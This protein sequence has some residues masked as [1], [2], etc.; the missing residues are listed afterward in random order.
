VTRFLFTTLPGTAH[1]HALGPVARAARTA[2]HDVAFATSASFRPAVEACGF[3][4]FGCGVDWLESELTETFPELARVD[5]STPQSAAH[6]M[7]LFAGRLAEAMA[8]DLWDVAQSWEPDL[9]VRDLLELGGCLVAEALDLTQAACGPTYYSDRLTL[10]AAV[11]PALTRLRRALNLPPDPGLELLYGHLELAFGPPSFLGDGAGAPATTHFLRP[12]PFDRF[13][14]AALPGTLERLSGRPT[15][16]A[17][18]GTV[19]NRTPGVFEAIVEALADAPYDV[20]LTIG[21]N[22][23][24]SEL[25]DVPANVRVV[26]YAPY[27]LLLPRCAAVITHGGTLTVTACLLASLP[28]LVLPVAGDQFVGARRCVAAGV[29]LALGR[30][31]RSPQ[32]IRHAVERLLAEPSFRRRAVELR[33]EMLNLPGPERAVELLEALVAERWKAAVQA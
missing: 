17:T 5:P 8:A 10:K 22:R 11:R 31:S 33:Q 19:S 32:L 7:E 12:E 14:A 15:I 13:E 16:L 27:S 23:D 21:G 28:V 25:G 6:V 24:P 20:V 3:A 29:G 18:M 9:I 2:G 1:L 4:C 26:G 30:S